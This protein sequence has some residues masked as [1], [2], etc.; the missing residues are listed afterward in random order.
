MMGNKHDSS[1]MDDMRMT[2]YTQLK[3]GDDDNSKRWGG[4]NLDI[5]PSYTVKDL[6]S[7]LKSVGTFTMTINGIFG[8]KTER[9][10]S[11][12]SGHA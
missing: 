8:P 1:T 10:L 12:F 6:Q 4:K 9:A 5:S 3:R 2:E 7:D 11:C